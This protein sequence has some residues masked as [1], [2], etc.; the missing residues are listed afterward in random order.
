MVVSAQG[1]AAKD[2]HTDTGDRQKRCYALSF[3]SDQ[4]HGLDLGEDI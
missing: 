3:S 4:A 2:R 1:V